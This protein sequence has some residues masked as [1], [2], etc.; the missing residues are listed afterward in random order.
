LRFFSCYL[1]ILVIVLFKWLSRCFD[2]L[3][4]YRKFSINFTII[5]PHATR[6]KS[7]I[8]HRQTFTTQCK[9]SLS[10]LSSKWSSTSI[11]SK[12]CCTNDICYRSLNAYDVLINKKNIR[13]KITRISIWT[14]F[15]CHINIL[16][17]KGKNIY[18]QEKTNEH[19]QFVILLEIFMHDIF[20]VY[21][22]W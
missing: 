17:D 5:I 7:T 15:V 1:L 9:Y 10:S 4:K 13:R 3:S 6:S 20:L 22:S 11:L 16:F 2:E 19:W 8:I 21:V 12:I 14:L 18:I